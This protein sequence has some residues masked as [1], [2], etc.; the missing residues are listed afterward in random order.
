[1]G[2]SIKAGEGGRSC[3]GTVEVKCLEG[4]LEHGSDGRVRTTAKGL[5]GEALVQEVVVVGG[6]GAVAVTR[7]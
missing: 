3:Q 4:L 6:G 1:M 2:G 7:H 5:K